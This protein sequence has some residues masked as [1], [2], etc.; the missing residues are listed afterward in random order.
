[1]HEP[2]RRKYHNLNYIVHP[3]EVANIIKQAFTSELEM[4]IT[5][6][7]YE[8]ENTWQRINPVLMAAYLH[9]VPEECAKQFWPRH[10]LDHYLHQQYLRGH[11]AEIKALFGNR[12]YELVAAKTCMNPF[13]KRDVRHQQEIEI[14]KSADWQLRLLFIADIA[15]NLPSILE[16]EPENSTFAERY[17]LEK[18]AIYNALE[19][20]RS[21]TGDVAFNLI[22][23]KVKH[24][25][26]Q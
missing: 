8:K 12:V 23:D 21:F 3:I 26:E 11:L 14:A 22:A 4:S 25:F 13:E 1:M 17:R 24:Y 19:R 16:N 10:P 5:E 15:S 6:S 7:E 18:K 9:D 20:S 2:H